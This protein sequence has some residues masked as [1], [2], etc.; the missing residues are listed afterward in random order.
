VARFQIPATWPA[1]KKAVLYN[2]T[3]PVVEGCW[4]KVQVNN[5]P[6]LTTAATGAQ[7]AEALREGFRIADLGR[8]KRA[9]ASWGI[10]ETAPPV[11]PPGHRVYAIG[12]IHLSGHFYVRLRAVA[13]FVGACSNDVVRNGPTLTALRRIV[14]GGSFRGGSLRGRR[15]TT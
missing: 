11:A 8:G 13:T 5:Q 3:P 10:D 6:R 1:V 7:V 14:I 2:L 12:V 4:I 15:L 9:H